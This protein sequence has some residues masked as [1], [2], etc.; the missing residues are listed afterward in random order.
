VAS[1]IEIRQ[2]LTLSPNAFTGRTDTVMIA[3]TA[4]NKGNRAMDVGTRVML[5]TMIGGNDDAPFFIPGTGN[6]DEEHEY[7]GAAVPSYWKAFEAR[8]YSPSSLKG[9]GIVTGFG[10]TPPDRFVAANWPRISDTVWDY[11]V[12][13]GMKLGDS[14]VALYWMPKQLQPRESVTWVTYYG[15][16]GTGG[17]TAWFDAPVMVT[18]ESPRFQATLWVSNNSDSDF[19]GGEAS[20]ILTPGLTLAS[21]EMLRKPFPRVPMG[22]GA[23]SVSWQLVAGGDVDAHYPYSATIAFASGS[24]QL[25]AKS[26]VGYQKVAVPVPTPCPTSLLP[27][28]RDRCWLWWPWLLLLIPLI[29]G[30]TPCCSRLAPLALRERLNTNVSRLGERPAKGEKAWRTS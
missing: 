2:V 22:G 28:N 18:T 7:S 14:A 26:S 21:G 13:P 1:D 8:D 19:T 27:F 3:T 5:D 16:A 17:G 25:V 12:T 30:P 29:G 15:L 11:P 10:A 24:P 6:T 4:A 23:Q 20:L 9:Q